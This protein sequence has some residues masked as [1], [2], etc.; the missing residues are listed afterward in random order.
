M[1]KKKSTFT[2]ELWIGVLGIIAILTIYLLINFFKGINIFSTG[3]KYYV[4]F[5]NIGEIVNTSPV[6]IN[7]YKVGHVSNVI[8]NFNNP[9]EV[10]VEMH[11]DN[12]LQMPVGSV[13]LINTKLLGSSTISLALGNGDTMIQPG[14]TLEGRMNTGAMDEAG[15]MLPKITAM[16][17]KLDSILVSL[18]STLANPAINKSVNNIETLTAELNNTAA[19]L[20]SVLKNDIPV[21]ADKLIKIEDDL[22]KM[23]AQLSEVDYNKLIGSLEASLNN[24]QEIT[25]AL[26]N[27]E[28]TAGMLLKDEALYNKLNNTAEAATLLL[29]DLK[30][31][32][33]RYV[34]FSV[35][36]KKDKE[37]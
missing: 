15:E 13:A 33:K 36:G 25:T 8:Y 37:K 18:N 19:L 2:R 32:P 35:F 3:E 10:H 21:A 26:N 23:S 14:D 1:E 12:Q 31:N 6:F 27:G 29:Q 5:S 9:D 24:I 28:G 11:L 7:G 22:L 16:L 34:H 4:K 20:N 17:P 30:K